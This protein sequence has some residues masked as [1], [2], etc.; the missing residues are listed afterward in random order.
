[1]KNM[2]TSLTKNEFQLV[3]NIYGSAISDLGGIDLREDLFGYYSIYLLQD[4]YKVD[5][6]KLHNKLEILSTLERLELLAKIDIFWNR[7]ESTYQILDL[8]SPKE[9]ICELLT[10]P[11][12]DEILKK[13]RKESKEIFYYKCLEYH[14]DYVIHTKDS[15]NKRNIWG[16][17]R[18]HLLGFTLSLASQ[19]QFTSSQKLSDAILNGF[20]A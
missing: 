20:K 3:C 13:S 9:M 17:A 2:N 5:T 6:Q 19:N 16:V 1:M 8:I 11:C 12:R 10:S 14:M 18:E 7:D 15:T 4:K